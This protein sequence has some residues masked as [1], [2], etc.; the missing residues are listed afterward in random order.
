MRTMQLNV[1]LAPLPTMFHYPGLQWHN[2]TLAHIQGLA[3]YRRQQ[4][5]YEHRIVILPMLIYG[6]CGIYAN[7][8]CSIRA[9]VCRSCSN[10][11]IVLVRPC[12]I[13]GNFSNTGVNSVDRPL[14]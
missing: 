7:V 14:D 10:V 3:F 12:G 13:Q 6:H 5:P 9:N 1:P 4:C 11:V 8:E 2:A